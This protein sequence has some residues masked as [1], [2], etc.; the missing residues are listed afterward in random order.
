MDQ[1]TKAAGDKKVSAALLGVLFWL[2]KNPE[3]TLQNAADRFGKSRAWIYR[4]KGF[5]SALNYDF[6]EEPIKPKPHV[7]ENSETMPYIVNEPLTERTQPV[8]TW[9]ETTLED[10]IKWVDPLL[11]DNDDYQLFKFY[12]SHNHPRP[13]E[14]KDIEEAR[15]AGMRIWASVTNHYVGWIN[16][17]TINEVL[18]DEPNE[19]AL[20]QAWLK[21]NSFGYRKQNISGVLDWYKDLAL[22][23][24]AEPWNN[25]RS[26][27]SNG[28]SSKQLRK[29]HGESTID[30][31]EV[32][33]GTVIVKPPDNNSA[34]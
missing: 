8:K 16:A 2:H 13:E 9:H 11:T 4:M 26:N 14:D 20:K 27:G 15:K 31:S 30:N 22:D 10:S 5:M 6:L 24:S 28:Y 1:P 34:R 29:E 17:P 33:Y 19:K 18:G 23:E 3:A 32:E 25:R 12:L 7:D 21:W